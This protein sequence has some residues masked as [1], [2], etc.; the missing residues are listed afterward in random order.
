VRFLVDVNAGGRLS[1][2]LVA[3]GYD[4]KQV[5]ASNPA[6]TDEEVLEWAASEQRIIITFDKDFGELAIAQ[7]KL[8][9]GIIRLPDVPY[10]Q[11]V[12]LLARVLER[13]S[14]DLSR[15][16]VITVSERRIRVR[17]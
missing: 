10:S 8:H 16:K 12:Y 14:N 9:C 11:R 13:Y 4:V 6:M 1:E 7:G 15:G 3:Q 5:A 2:W 17:G